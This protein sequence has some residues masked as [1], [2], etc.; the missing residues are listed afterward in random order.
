MVFTNLCINKP[1]AIS[2]LLFLRANLLLQDA[3]RCKDMWTPPD[4]TLAGRGTGIPS[5]GD[6]GGGTNK[7]DQT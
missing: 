5:E 4:G 1:D 6:W 7:R 3:V 2:Q